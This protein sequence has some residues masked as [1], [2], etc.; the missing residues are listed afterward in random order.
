MEKKKYCR[1][2]MQWF[3]ENTEETASDSCQSPVDWTT[4]SKNTG[5]ERQGQ[6]MDYIYKQTNKSSN[7]YCKHPGPWTWVKATLGIHGTERT[8]IKLKMKEV[9]ETVA[10]NSPNLSK[11][12]TSKNRSHWEIGMTQGEHFPWYVIL[13]MTKVTKQKAELR[14]ENENV[15]SFVRKIYQLTPDLR[16]RKTWFWEPDKHRAVFQI[17]KCQPGWWG[18]VTLAYICREKKASRQVQTKTIHEP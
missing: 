10:E 5:A 13:Q 16:A 17:N 12:G 14:A 7:P 9:K 8:E 3:G 1:W 11:K 4:P 18:P 6:E 2:K 15:N